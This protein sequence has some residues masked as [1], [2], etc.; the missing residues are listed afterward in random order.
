MDPQTE[1]REMSGDERWHAFIAALERVA[2][3]DAALRGLL[4]ALDEADMSCERS[5]F[6]RCG[7]CGSCEL[8]KPYRAARSLLARNA[9][10]DVN[11]SGYS[12]DEMVW[13]SL[14]RAIELLTVVARAALAEFGAVPPPEKDS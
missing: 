6:E 7:A 2:A 14:R 12:D 8:V 1:N 13:E 4:D 5:V 3:L 9:K 10:E 11:Q